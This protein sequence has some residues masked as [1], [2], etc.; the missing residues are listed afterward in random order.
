RG[1][2]V[3]T[4]RVQAFAAHDTW[5]AMIGHSARQYPDAFTHAALAD[6]GASVPN[7]PLFFRLPV[8]LSADGRWLQ[9]SQTTPRLFSA[10]MRVL[11]LDW[12]FDDP[13][14]KS[15]PDF[16]DVEQRTEYYELLLAAVRS[17]TADEWQRVFDDEPD[18]WAEI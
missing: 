5:N 14:W 9:F 2:R 17:K 3:A 13:R 1:Q 10:F 4:T 7:N 16:D 8:V 12:M 6:D 18:V 11:G 15:V